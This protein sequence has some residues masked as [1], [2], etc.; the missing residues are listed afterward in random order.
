MNILDENIPRNQRELLLS[1][2]IP[3][4]QIGYDIGHKGIQDD[5]IIPV[6][7]KLKQPTFFTRDFDFFNRKLCH[8]RYALVYLEVDKAEVAT[9]VRRTLRHPTLNSRAKRMG[10]VLCISAHNLL[11]YQP[12]KVELT[13]LN[14]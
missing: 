12:H 2:R 3:I 10:L 7:H 4:R 6:L 13:T 8:P 1:W 14:W 11:V 9:F 5:E